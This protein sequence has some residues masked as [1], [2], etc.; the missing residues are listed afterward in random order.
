MSAP[1]RHDADRLAALL[2]WNARGWDG[3]LLGD[4]SRR[5]Y[6]LRASGYRGPIDQDGYPDTTSEGAAILRR[7]AEHRGEEVDW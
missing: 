2:P 1:T 7:M 6:A 4:R 5:L 3:E